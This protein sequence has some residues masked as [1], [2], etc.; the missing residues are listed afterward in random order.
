M[1]KYSGSGWHK[2]SARHSRA[3]KTGHAGGEYSVRGHFRNKGKKNE[4]WI[5]Y[6]TVKPKKNYGKE[7]K[8]KHFGY[9]QKGFE[10]FPINKEYEIIAHWEKTR[11]GFRHVVRLMHNG[12]EVDTATA[13]YQNRTWERFEYESAINKLLEKTNLMTD[14]ERK[15][16]L[17]LLAKKDEERINKEFGMIG[18]IAQMGEVLTGSKKESNDWKERMIKAGLPQIDIPEDWDTLSEDEKEAR[19]NK[20]IEFMKKK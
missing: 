3:R 2:E 11:N 14:K 20:V 12:S 17:D 15:E 4:V 10:T 9:A 16:Y 7:Q 18:A 19:L 13:N 6:H 5:Q 1:A 8:Q